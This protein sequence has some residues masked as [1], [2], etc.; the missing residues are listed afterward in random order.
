MQDSC[1]LMWLQALSAENAAVLCSLHSKA[2]S[3]VC[4]LCRYYK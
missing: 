1:T 4:L 3:D 2:C